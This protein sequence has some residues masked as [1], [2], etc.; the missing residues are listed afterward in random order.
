MGGSKTYIKT[1]KTKLTD[2]TIL[3]HTLSFNIFLCIININ[4]IFTWLQCLLFTALPFMEDLRQFMFAPLNEN[5]KWEP[6]SE[7]EDINL[8]I[9]MK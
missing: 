2:P 3:K 6:S 1:K 8:F 9:I 5:K 7:S 4:L